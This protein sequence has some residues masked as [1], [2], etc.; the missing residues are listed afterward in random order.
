MSARKSHKTYRVKG[1]PPEY[2]PSNVGGFLTRLLE[3]DEQDSDVE[4][5][6]LTSD[7]ERKN[8]K[9]ATFSS[10]RLEA[11]LGSSDQWYKP[12]PLVTDETLLA[13]KAYVTLDTKFHDFTPLAVPEGGYRFE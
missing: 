2:G 1:I 3:L 13:R 11:T 7:L 4:L 9:V 12:L 10:S 5:G 8:E 6:S